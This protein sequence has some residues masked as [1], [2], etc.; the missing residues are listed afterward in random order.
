MA[1]SLGIPVLAEGAENE[2]QLALLQESGC[3]AVQGFYFG[4]PKT[5]EQLRAI[6][7]F[8]KEGD[9]ARSLLKKRSDSNS[10]RAA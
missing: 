1:N 2:E 8:R 6:T 10:V 3:E 5:V 4:R 9:A 7:G